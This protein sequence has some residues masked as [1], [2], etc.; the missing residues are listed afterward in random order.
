MRLCMPVHVHVH[1]HVPV[2]AFREW[3]NAPERA[4]AP[5]RLQWMN[6]RAKGIDMLE[7]LRENRQSLTVLERSVD[8]R[9]HAIYA[10]STADSAALHGV[11]EK[12]V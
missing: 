7:Y 8:E 10:E 12:D 2:Q 1:V 5:E 11:S 3:W 4:R 6:F 9:L